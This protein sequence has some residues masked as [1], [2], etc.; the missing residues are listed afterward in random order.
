VTS[1]VLVVD[2]DRV[3]GLD[4]ATLLQRTTG[5]PALF[6]ASVEEALNAVRTSEISVAV[7]D[8][9]MEAVLGV[10]GTQL[11]EKIRNVDPRVRFII[12][13]GQAEQEDVEYA[14]DLEVR[15]LRKQRIEELPGIVHQ[16]YTRYL[17]D[18]AGE[19]ENRAVR[20]GSYRPPGIFNRSTVHI[21]LMAVERVSD[22]P[23]AREGDY[24]TIAQLVAGQKTETTVVKRY[25]V[26]REFEWERKNE[27]QISIP[28]GSAAL[29]HLAPS[30]ESSIRER[31]KVSTRDSSEHTVRVTYSL[32]SQ[33]ITA[34][35]VMRRI[36][37]APLF[38]RMRAIVKLTCDCCGLT[39]TTLLG[40]RAWSG[41]FTEL[42][43][44][45]MKDGKANIIDLGRD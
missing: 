23:E 38:F 22:E 27:L 40:F 9:R 43:D 15:F 29:G 11:V 1:K 34:G 3:A 45:R 5:L 10:S 41:F 12:F 44:D 18:L 14:S 36:K 2:D 35:V 7:I 30:V 19:Y 26:E 31:S 20:I 17:V 25:E 28:L 13:S 33:D 16:F 6:A 24:E 4:Y 8:Q 21:D 42:Q 37:R 32:P 39:D